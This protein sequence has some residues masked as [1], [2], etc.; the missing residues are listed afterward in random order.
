METH[1]AKAT[2]RLLPPS[3]DDPAHRR[4]P[5]PAAGANHACVRG[6]MAQP[7]DG[8]R[9][10]EAP[11]TTQELHPGG[12]CGQDAAEVSTGPS[13]PP[14]P[15]RAWVTVTKLGQRVLG[16]ERV[17][18]LRPRGIPAQR[19]SCAQAA[20]AGVTPSGGWKTNPHAVTTALGGGTRPAGPLLAL[21]QVPCDARL[22]G[23]RARDGPCR[24]TA[25][26]APWNQAGPQNTHPLRGTKQTP[27]PPGSAGLQP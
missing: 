6:R 3:F 27:P 8:Q 22:R 7:L 13:P 15:P 5:D 17:G 11:C 10:S 26:P 23:P 16:Q 12:R 14:P 19:T 4:R 24:A 2:A 21:R 9:G 20:Q 25:P 18:G 1:S